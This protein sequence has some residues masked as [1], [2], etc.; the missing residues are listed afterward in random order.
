MRSSGQRNKF[1]KLKH[2]NNCRPSSK[3]WL[4]RQLNDPYVIQS[5]SQGYRSRA[6]YKLIEINEKFALLKPGMKIID[7][8]AA[9][10]SWSQVASKITKADEPNPS[11]KIIALDLLEIDS[12]PGVNCIQ[13]DF[14]DE[15]AK[16][17]IRL[18]LAGNCA[19]L[20][21]SDMAPNSTG[22]SPTDQLRIALLCEHSLDFALSILS[23]GG[24]FIAK[25]FQGG[26]ESGLLNK[27]KRNFKIVKHFKPAASRKESKELYLIGLNR[28]IVTL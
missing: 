12:I 19:D 9:P 16:Q 7:L 21:M 5:K 4:E 22:H 11:S 23:P 20:L 14:L 8:G 26:I 6:A 18:E 13:K 17:L 27:I 24:H 28:K 25:T 15:D 2:G 3:K 10:G 1:I